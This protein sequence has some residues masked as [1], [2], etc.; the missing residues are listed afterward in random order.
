MNILDKIQ[1]QDVLS[2][3]SDKIIILDVDCLKAFTYSKIQNFI[4]YDISKDVRDY[5]RLFSFLEEN[6]NVFLLTNNS[7]FNLHNYFYDIICNSSK[8]GGVKNLCKSFP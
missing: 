8:N 1:I 6:D 2:N 4:L 7:E 3:N 5:V